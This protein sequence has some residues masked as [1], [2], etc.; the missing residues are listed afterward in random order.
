[1]IYPTASAALGSIIPAGADTLVLLRRV[2]AMPGDQPLPPDDVRREKTD[3][4]VVL[5]YR[6]DVKHA[7]ACSSW[8]YHDSNGGRT[9][10]LR[11]GVYRAAYIKGEHRGRDAIV[12]QGFTPVRVWTYTIEGEP[13]GTDEGWLGINIHSDKGVSEGCITT[14]GEAPI[15]ALRDALEVGSRVHPSGAQ[16][17]DLYVLHVREM[18]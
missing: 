3:R 11:P 1:L 4:L 12:Q 16:A 15:A 7:A 10:L 18:D 8:S 9:V 17:H 13:M 6:G 2:D 5:D 14:E